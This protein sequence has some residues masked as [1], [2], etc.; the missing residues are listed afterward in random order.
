MWAF[1]L[2]SSVLT[3]GTPAPAG[4]SLSTEIE[5]RI[6]FLAASEQL[7]YEFLIHGDERAAARDAYAEYS[8]KKLDVPVYFVPLFKDTKALLGICSCPMTINGQICVILVDN[9]ATKS[10]GQLSTLVHEIAHTLQGTH[11]TT[12]MEAELWAETV[13]WLVQR[14]LGYDTTRESISYLALIPEAV[15]RTFLDA[16]EKE[17]RKTVEK[18]V[19]V[20]KKN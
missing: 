19:K 12:S 13:A 6:Q 7:V 9:S 15:R 18:L 10:N 3:I 14:K 4:P 2:L 20:V 16:K 5:T 1:L 11:V 17:I 8:R